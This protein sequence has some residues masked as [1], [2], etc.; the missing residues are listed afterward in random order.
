MNNHLQTRKGF[1][2]ILCHIAVIV[3]IAAL[4]LAVTDACAGTIEPH[5]SRARLHEELKAKYPE[6]LPWATV[7]AWKVC[8]RTGPGKEYA[9]QEQWG[10][11]VAVEVI[12]TVDGWAEVLH[13][14]S[15]EPLWVWREYLTMAPAQ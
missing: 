2:L 10:V 15:P 6:G 7:N 9:V 13:W 3:G 11:G 1:L 4:A 12:R 14:T 8:F 5:Y